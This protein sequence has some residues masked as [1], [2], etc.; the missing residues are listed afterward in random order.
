MERATF[1]K[2]KNSI[3]EHVLTSGT[4]ENHTGE[5]KKR[6]GNAN[7]NQIISADLLHYPERVP[8]FLVQRGTS[9]GEEEVSCCTDIHAKELARVLL[10]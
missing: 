10:K 4:R 6:D 3:T 2:V 7:Q 9:V 1:W 5:M 8:V